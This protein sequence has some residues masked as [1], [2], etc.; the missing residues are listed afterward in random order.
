MSNALTSKYVCELLRYFL[1]TICILRDVELYAICCQSFLFVIWSKQ[2]ARSLTTIIIMSSSSCGF[3]RYGRTPLHFAYKEE[4]LETAKV[5]LDRGAS[6]DKK[7]NIGCSVLHEVR[8]MGCGAMWGLAFVM[9]VMMKLVIM[10]TMMIAIVM[11][12]SLSSSV[13]CHN[14]LMM[15]KFLSPDTQ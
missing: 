11:S 14:C 3:V 1:F 2:A 15:I 5:V 4:K 6:I 12:I 9:I 8:L 13:Q 10:V 7:D